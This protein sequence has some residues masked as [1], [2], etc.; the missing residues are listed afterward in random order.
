MFRNEQEIRCV[1]AARIREAFD[2]GKGQKRRERLIKRQMRKE[3]TREK[4]V[5]II[6]DSMRE[7]RFTTP[8]VAVPSGI[9][10]KMSLGRQ[11]A[12][13]GKIFHIVRRSRYKSSLGMPRSLSSFE[14]V[15]KIAKQ[16]TILTRMKK[17]S[18][19]YRMLTTTASRRSPSPDSVFS[20][21]R[22]EHYTT[23]TD[24]VEKTNT[25]AFCVEYEPVR[26]SGGTEK[27]PRS[28]LGHALGG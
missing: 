28:G 25:P 21:P 6:R 13:A 16:T 20:V 26:A 19:M 18:R 4:R 5:R 27:R 1:E 12:S 22:F 7:S 9:E 2:V 15:H 11:A 3:R 17:D 10:E 24:R 8:W 14:K 23:T